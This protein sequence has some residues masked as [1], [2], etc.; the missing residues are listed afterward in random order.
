MV[1]PARTQRGA[2]LS[3]RAPLSIQ[4]AR[5]FL[6]LCLSVVA[7]EFHV[8]SNERESVEPI[9]RF[10][11]LCPR[12]GELAKQSLSKRPIDCFAR[13]AQELIK[14]LAPLLSA[15]SDLCAACKVA[16]TASQRLLGV[17]ENAAVASQ[18]M[19][20]PHSAFVSPKSQRRSN[21]H[22]SC[23]PA[24]SQSFAI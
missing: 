18:L 21:E 16:L 11:V 19:R 7:C 8:A 6:H 3:E 17:T 12:F 5:A 20:K 24:S 9:G 15:H 10:I 23:K 4:R 1:I 22:R 2:G 14:H 13:R